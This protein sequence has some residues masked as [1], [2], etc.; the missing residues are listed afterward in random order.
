MAVFQPMHLVTDPAL[1]GASS[2]P[3]FLM[4][5]NSDM[6]GVAVDGLLWAGF[7][8]TFGQSAAT[9]QLWEGACF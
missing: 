3:Q 6:G 1:S 8:T 7:R 5:L 9:V 2:L 4:C